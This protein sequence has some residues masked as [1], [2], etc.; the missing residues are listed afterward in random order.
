MKINEE[1]ERL[2]GAD[3]YRQQRT[4]TVGNSG[5]EGFES[6]LADQMARAADGATAT[7][8][9]SPEALRALADPLRLAGLSLSM[10][11]G[12]TASPAAEDAALL[13]S[14][15]S[16]LDASLKGLDRYA[17][18]LSGGSGSLR[19]AWASLSTLEENLADLRQEMGRLSQP[20]AELDSLLN[21]LEVLAAAEKFKFN[22][23][24]YLPA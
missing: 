1:L 9:A 19:E 14:L 3:S 20:D 16:G 2:L 5:G 21:E 6:L 15:T 18:E 22:R 11:D 7:S 24:D 10:A 17:A 13:A 23:G 8:G 4:R 12:A